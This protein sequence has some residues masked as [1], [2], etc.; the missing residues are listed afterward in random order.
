MSRALSRE[1]PGSNAPDGT[2]N[3]RPTGPLRQTARSLW[4]CPTTSTS[5]AMPPDTGN[6]LIIPTSRCDA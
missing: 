1:T 6:I 5:L 3:E 2:T 4:H